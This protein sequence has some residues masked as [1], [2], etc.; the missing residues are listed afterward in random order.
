MDRRFHCG[1]IQIDL[2]TKRDELNKLDVPED[3]KAVIVIRDVAG[4]I[5]L[6]VSLLETIVAAA[7]HL[8][9]ET[10]RVDAT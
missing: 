8:H 5:V 2:I 7:E 4:D 10:L 9:D 1:P 3:V 6:P